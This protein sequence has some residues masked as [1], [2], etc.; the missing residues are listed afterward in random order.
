MVKLLDG[1]MDIYLFE[2]QH[3]QLQVNASQGAGI[4]GTIITVSAASQADCNAAGRNLVEVGFALLRRF[5][6]LSEAEVMDLR[7]ELDQL[8]E[9]NRQAAAPDNAKGFP[10]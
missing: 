6:D 7:E 3:F 8:I 2:D 5:G 1:S 4:D 10:F 9:G